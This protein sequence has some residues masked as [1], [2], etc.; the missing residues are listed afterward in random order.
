MRKRLRN[1]LPVGA[2]VKFFFMK[3]FFFLLFLVQSCGCSTLQRV[4][5]VSKKIH[6]VTFHDVAKGTY[7][8]IA[9]PYCDTLRLYPK[10]KTPGDAILIPDTVSLPLNIDTTSLSAVRIYHNGRV[11]VL[12]AYILFNYEWDN[13]KVSRSGPGRRRW[14]FCP[15][16]NFLHEL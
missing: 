5:C 7:R 9:V 8:T 11:F 4:E 10:G 12:Y 14:E 3:C 2:C 16:E 6:F 13:L 15:G 1:Y